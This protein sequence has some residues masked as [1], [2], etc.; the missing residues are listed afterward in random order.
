MEEV[1]D[2]K[3][4]MIDRFGNPPKEVMMLIELEEIRTLAS[5]LYLDEILEQARSIKIKI[6][7]HSRIDAGKLVRLIAEDRRLHVD[8]KDNGILIFTPV[9]RLTEKK[10]PELKKWLQ[11]FTQ[12]AQ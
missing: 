5:A 11:Q 4:E 9:A 3:N 2:L 10:I 1:E 12:D 8:P 6:S 7:G